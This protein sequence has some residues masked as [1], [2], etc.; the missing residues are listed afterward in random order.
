MINGLG[1]VGWGVG[2]IEA[3]AVMLGQPLTLVTPQVVGFKLEGRLR[4]GVTAT[5]LVLT[6]TQM[7]RKKGVVD[8]FVEFFGKGL[9]TM[10]LP[11]RATLA[12]MAPEY[13]ATI[14]FFPVDAETLRYLERTDRADAA[15][16]TEAYCKQQGLFC[17]DD[18]PD[19]EFS[20]TVSLDL[21]DVEPS[22]AGP[23][24]PQ[25]RVLLR[26]MKGAF[27][28][29]LT[30]PV[31]ERGYGLAE[32][33]HG[34]TAAAR[35]NGHTDTLGHGAVVIAAITSCTNT[36]NPSVMVGAGLL[37]RKAVARGLQVKP[38]VKTSMAPGSKVVTRY[39]ESADLM[40]DL[41]ALGFNVVGYG[42]TTCI[43][44]RTAVL[45]QSGI[46]TPIERLA[47]LE[48]TRLMSPD[49]AARL[50][51]ATPTAHLEQGVKDC[52]TLV[53]QD[54]R[55]LV[56]TPDHRLLR[57][58]GAWVRAD[59]L[60]PGRDRVITGLEAP[61]D[62]I[63]DDERDYVLEIG[64]M[65]FAM[66]DPDERGRA[67][68]F[69]RLLGH[70]LGDGSISANGQGRMCAGQW[71]D[72]EAMLADL[73]QLTG[74][75]PLA[76]RYDEHKWTIV[77]PLELTNAIWALDGVT[78][79]RRITQT[80]E[81]PAFVRAPEC[82]V[83]LVREFL[84]GMFGADGHAPILKRQG[85][86]PSD[87][88]LVAPAF[89][90]SAVAEHLDSLRAT[91]HEIARLLGRCGVHTEHAPIHEYPT[92]RSA[93]SYPAARD[94]A[95]RWEVRL[96]LPDGLSFVERVGFRYCVDKT[97]R[98]SAAAVYWRTV[99]G[100]GRQRI[101]M[102][103]LLR[104]IHR[105]EPGLSFA[106]ARARAASVLLEHEPAFHT[107]FSLLAGHDRFDRLP[108]AGARP[109]QPLHRE[110]AGFPSP[111][112][113]L[114]A[115]GAREWFSKL[116]GRV[117]VV[118]DK[119][120]CVEKEAT[121]LPTLSLG[122]LD[123][124]PAG[125][126]FVYDLTV[127]E[128]H[129]FVA[130]TVCVHNC[131]GN[132]GP[133]PEPVA[134]AVDEGK[135][136]AAAV[137][138]GN[139]NFEGRVNPLTRA[140]Y[141]ASPP[142][143]VAYALAGTVDIDL[144]KDP[145]GNGSDGRPVYLRDIWPTQEE[146]RDTIAVSLQPEMFHTSYGNTFDGNPRWNAIPVAGGERYTWDP[147]S[148]YIHEPPFFQ[149]LTLEPTPPDDIIGARVLVM[150]ADSVTTDHISPAG[151]IALDS[152]AGRFLREHGV[153]KK[154]FNSYGARRGNDLVMVRGTFA[155]IRLKN[156]LVPG[157]EGNVTIHFPSG[158]ST[159][160][161]DAS[162][163]YRR[164]GTPLIVLAGKEYGTGSSRDWAAKGTLLLGVRAVLAESFERIHRSNLVGMGV[165]PLVYESGQSAETLGLTGRETFDV[166]GLSGKLTP[167]QKVTV[168]AR[169]EDGSVVEFQAIARLDTPVDVD[170]YRNGGIL[171]TV[172]RSLVKA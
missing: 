24:R 13:G 61:V 125:P 94:G 39:L 1:V 19:P 119:R 52:V 145:L 167:R 6:V 116:E 91:M 49:A 59:R 128:H 51:P 71:L 85:A 57:A 45:M 86:D 84:G 156:Q 159:S 114:T 147:S 136:V 90:R 67:L 38:Y 64:A 168:R 139:R 126:R 154:D 108:A 106:N 16:L 18:T 135:L 58:D 63:G 157:S 27:R 99:R 137:L 35:T 29:T 160:I 165:L 121:S 15:R 73:A 97:L 3:E 76:T 123:R 68:A 4:D 109:F 140:N 77:L 72:R 95:P 47:R 102:G 69:A 138:S 112:E 79:G 48:D 118:E 161:F 7:L 150:V 98:A 117:G 31:K 142:L 111:A 115:I 80:H 20:D 131:I 36:S 11:D 30:A 34:R 132:S 17:T 26:E 43:A 166:R 9:G 113:V 41:E 21:G 149:G 14:G 65:R 158:E 122:V 12:N 130:G 62:V 110:T 170:Y 54:G 146:I 22:V 81:L 169:R 37:A 133:L 134:A 100:I 104:S 172:L 10:S 50:T 88:V 171:H 2:G 32:T 155:N 53:L 103:D 120:Y 151:D 89:S 87:A 23:K 56:C 8:K 92:R 152:P 40:K 144:E 33:D 60:E 129:A 163:R 143:V 55:E 105:Q 28:R 162:E 44:A 93:S 164:D 66:A 25:D 148:T 74:R 78:T 42:C 141:L 101:Q 153:E 124:R 83:A 75:R 82:P 96:Q 127:A 46:A 5:D 70:L 107:H